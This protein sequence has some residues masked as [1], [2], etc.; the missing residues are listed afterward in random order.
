MTEKV[1]HGLPGSWQPRPPVGAA[2]RRRLLRPAR[3]GAREILCDRGGHGCY[4]PDRTIRL[5]MD[6][7]TRTARTCWRTTLLKSDAAAL[8]EPV[9]LP[10]REILVG[11]HH[12][13]LFRGVQVVGSQSVKPGSND[14]GRGR[15]RVRR[16]PVPLTSCRQMYSLHVGKCRGMSANVSASGLAGRRVG[17]HGMHGT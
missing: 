3:P 8:C 1:A 15:W 11:D 13:S 5:G 16:R 10:L 17:Q 14:R 2:A 6:C 7:G 12:D 9:L 4:R